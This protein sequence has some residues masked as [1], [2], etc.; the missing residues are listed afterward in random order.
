M[1]ILEK[2][3]IDST[4][5]LI[6]QYHKKFLEP[7]GIKLPALYSK[8]AYTRNGLVLVYLAQGYPDTKIVTKNELTEYLS[9]FFD[10][11][12]DVQQARHLG[13]QHGFYII[14]GQRNDYTQE[15]LNRGEY[16]LVSLE[17]AYPGFKKDR[18]I[19][20]LDSFE[21]IKEAYDNRCATCGSKEDE[22]HLNW[23]NTKTSL[24]AGHMNPRKPL[25][26]GNIIPQ[27][28]QCNKADRDRWVYDEKGRVV[29]LSNP[30]AILMSDLEVQKVVYKILKD[31]FENL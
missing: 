10:S 20:E 17:E 5:A 6:K 16:K 30:T 11:V 24:T 7:L 25:I 2:T 3:T 21:Q 4:Y 8:G 13:A 14:S 29:A 15:N 31:K 28:S 19:F 18:R 26:K 22:P 27:C 12:A 23:P 9:E 1:N